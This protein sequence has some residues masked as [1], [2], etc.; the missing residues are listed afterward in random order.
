[1]SGT[2][3]LRAAITG[4]I[5]FA[6]TEEEIL[7]ASAPDGGPGS[8]QCWSAAP[9]VAHNTEFR[10]QQVVRLHAVARGETP[11][12]FA[13]IDHRSPETYGRYGAAAATEVIR[14]ARQSVSDLIDGLGAVPDADLTDASRHPWLR[15]RQLWLQ[16]VVRGFWHPTGHLGDYHI[17]HGQPAR[18]VA[19]HQ[20]ALATARYLEVPDMALGMAAYSLACAQAQAGAT[21][22][23][24]HTLTEAITLNQ[25]LR[26]NAQEDPDLARLRDSGRLDPLAVPLGGN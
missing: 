22:D 7:L 9:L 6:A 15:G 12:A 1:M 21:G 2:S 17:S 20:H 5:G 13:E 25:D 3:A 26:A 18:A 14:L 19:L 23:A 4:L 10:Q 24:L 16:V 11:P 8:P